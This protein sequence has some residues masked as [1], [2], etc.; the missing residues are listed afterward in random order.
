MNGADFIDFAAKIAATYADAASCRSAISR[1]YY[2]A[3]HLAKSFLDRIDSRPP[4]NAN[5][6]VFVQRRLTSCGHS[7]AA[8]AGF[9]LADLYAD[10]LSADYNLEKKPVESVAYARM[11]VVRAKRIQ[12]SLEACDSQQARDQIRAGIADYERK[13]SGRA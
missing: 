8:E 12:D 13:I 2:G 4:R 10:R 1:A 3:F 5:A 9:L 11:G 6:H 7:Q